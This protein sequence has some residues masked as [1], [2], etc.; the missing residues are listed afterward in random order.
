MNAE[1]VALPE[2]SEETPYLLRI[3][4][5]PVAN[6]FGGPPEPG[7]RVVDVLRESFEVEFFYLFQ[8]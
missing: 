8:G 7:W 5:A 4:G 3:Q 2:V 6:P 1:A